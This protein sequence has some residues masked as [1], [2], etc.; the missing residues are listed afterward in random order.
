MIAVEFQA[1]T[2]EHG[3]RGGVK[4]LSFQVPK[5]G[6]LAII[7]P[8]GCGKT[9]LLRLLAGLIAPDRGRISLCGSLASEAGR[10]VTPPEARR[11]GM[12]FQDL[13]LWP[14]MTVRANVAFGLEAQGLAA[15]EVSRR[16]E[17]ALRMAGAEALAPARPNALSGGEQQ[18][19]ALARA[20]ALR[21][22]ILLMDEPLSSL[23]ER[24][25]RRLRK[26]ILQLQAAAGFALI[27]VTH[28]MD[29]ARVMAERVLALG[30]GRAV[31]QGPSKDLDGY[32]QSE[33]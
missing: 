13:A 32:L 29:E 4:E 18:R 25:A 10:V 24:L 17:E 16:I 7:G 12:V 5:G 23:D 8:S 26:E 6:R 20:L 30:Q 28:N 1:V 11:V 22:D 9:T 21:P 3:E 2:K 15:T 27:Y 31:W 33:P 19:V 14:H